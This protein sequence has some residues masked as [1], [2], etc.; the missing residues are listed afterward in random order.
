M[1]GPAVPRRK[2]SFYVF[3]LLSFS[4]TLSS[5]TP[6]RTNECTAHNTHTLSEEGLRSEPVTPCYRNRTRDRNRMETN[7]RKRPLP[8][9]PGLVFLSQLRSGSHNQP[10]FCVFLLFFSY[11]QHPLPNTQYSTN[12]TTNNPPEIGK[13]I[14]EVGKKRER[15]N[16]DAKRENKRETVRQDSERSVISARYDAV[17]VV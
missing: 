17:G 1:N 3:V 7:A 12:K 14:T 9:N 11:F 13:V 10:S 15:G 2:P 16:T 5:S 6:T 4:D 8:S